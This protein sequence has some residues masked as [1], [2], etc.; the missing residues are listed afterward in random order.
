MCKNHHPHHSWNLIFARC[1]AHSYNTGQTCGG[2][3]NV[4]GY[5]WYPWTPGSSNDTSTT[6]HFLWNIWK[7]AAVQ[8]RFEQKTPN[9]KD[10]STSFHSNLVVLWTPQSPFIDFYFYF[11]EKVLKSCYKWAIF[12]LIQGR[13]VEYS[14]HFPLYNILLMWLLIILHLRSDFSS[15]ILTD[16]LRRWRCLTSRH[17][18]YVSLRKVWSLLQ[19]I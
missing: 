18:F 7:A 1:H 10:L 11:K 12:G 9:T 2:S 15:K 3:L 16:A 6:E 5:W 13:L 14:S 8:Q 17:C 19:N 4:T